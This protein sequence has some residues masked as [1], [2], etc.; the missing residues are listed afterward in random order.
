MIIIVI[1]MV[2]YIYIQAVTLSFLLSW[3]IRLKQLIG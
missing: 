1:G 3:F 2:E